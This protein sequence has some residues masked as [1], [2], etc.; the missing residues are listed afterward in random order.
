VT[1][2]KPIA[3]KERKKEIN[4]EEVL[5]FYFIPDTTRDDELFDI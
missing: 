4:K 5:L 3:M 2:G 1:G